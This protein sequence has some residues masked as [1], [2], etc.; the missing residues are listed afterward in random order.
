[1]PPSGNGSWSL[2][3]QVWNRLRGPLRLQQRPALEPGDRR[4]YRTYTIG[5]QGQLHCLELASGQADLEARPRGLSTACRRTFFGTASTPLVEGRLFIVN[6]GAPGGPCVVGLDKAT[7]KEVWRAG[8]E[9]GP[10]YASPVPAVRS[11]DSDAYSCSQEANRPP[12]GGLISIDPATGKVDFSFPWRSRTYESVNASCP[13]V[14]DNKVFISASYRAGGALSRF[15]PTSRTRLPGPRRSSHCTSTLRATRR[16]FLRL[17]R[18]ERVRRVARLRRCGQRQGRVARN[19]RMD[20]GRRCRWR[21]TAAD[22]RNL[23]RIAA[24]RRRAVPVP[25]RARPLALDGSDPEGIPRSL[26]RP[27]VCRRGS[28]GRCRC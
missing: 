2:A 26:A 3:V 24:G 21:A 27:I 11:T 7:G 15:G 18:T 23:P 9:W 5:A 17:R 8:K 1:M 6:V 16:I 22:D 13:V 4:V 19:A 12:A 25:R 10:S 20:R 28:R 14:F